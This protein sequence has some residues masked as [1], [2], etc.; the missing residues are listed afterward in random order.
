MLSTMQNYAVKVKQT[1]I[2]LKTKYQFKCKSSFKCINY[3]SKIIYIY[4][5]H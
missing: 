2:N 4:F 5:L 1:Y 3:M